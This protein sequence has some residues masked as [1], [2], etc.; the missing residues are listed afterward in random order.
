MTLLPQTCPQPG[1]VF[2]STVAMAILYKKAVIGNYNLYSSRP[3]GRFRF[4]PKSLNHLYEKS[5]N[6]NLLWAK[7]K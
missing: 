3:N 7:T 1:L 4:N 5:G 2:F 6:L